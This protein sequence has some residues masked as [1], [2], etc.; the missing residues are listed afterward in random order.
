MKVKQVMTPYVE[1]VSPSTTIQEA[2]EKMKSMD[3]GALLVCDNEQIVGVVTDR[4]IAIRAAATGADT[5]VTPVQDIMT[6]HV[7]TCFEEQDV[8]D[9]AEIMKQKQIRRL[10]VLNHVS[11]LVGIVSL[12]DLALRQDDKT[13]VAETLE[14]VSACTS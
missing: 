14:H 7:A 8:A 1:C 2:A 11:R 5:S 4:D 6:P 10:A 13:L 9:A 12:G 3:V